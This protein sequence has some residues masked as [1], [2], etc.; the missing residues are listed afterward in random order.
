MAVQKEIKDAILRLIQQKPRT[1]QEIAETIGKNWRTADRYVELI[2]QETGLIAIRI[3]R[4]GSRGALK[5]VYWNSLE[6][7]KGSAYQE[8]LLQRIMQGN[9]KEDF[10]PLDIYQFVDPDNRKAFI[11]TTEFSQQQQIRFDYLLS[12]AQQQILFFSG[13]LSWVELGPNI[14][15]VLENLARKKIR[16]KV[17]TRVD[18]TSQKNTEEMLSLNQRVGWDAVEIRHCEQPLR[19]IIVDDGFVSIKEVM[20]PLYCR[21]LKEKK[22]MFYLIQ[23]TEWIQWLQKVFWNL[24]GQ[25][26]DAKERIA[27]LD[28]V[29][30]V[31]NTAPPKTL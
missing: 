10:S 2:A 1:V 19:A 29:N 12:Q 31:K 8:R 22:F 15:R 27:A 30:V 18:I 14:H 4:E 6:R 21:E 25:S 13:N 28:S 23:D 17:L 7:A 3:F 16:I 20:S 5:V 26:I 9:R 11:E 24:W